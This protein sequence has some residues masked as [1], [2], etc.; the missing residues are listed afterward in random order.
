[1]ATIMMRFSYFYQIHYFLMTKKHLPAVN[2]EILPDLN[3]GG[4]WNENYWQGIIVV[5]LLCYVNTILM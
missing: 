2:Q 3:F 1:M 4:F 5:D